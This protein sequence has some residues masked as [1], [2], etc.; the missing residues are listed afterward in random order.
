MRTCVGLL[1]GLV[2]LAG[3]GSPESGVEGDLP[4]EYAE[5]I[6]TATGCAE[7]QEVFDTAETTSAA[8]RDGGDSEGA[9]QYTAVM[10]AADERMRDV[11]C[12][13]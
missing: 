1:L 3:C 7:L 13:D 9:G 2:L 11:G 5:I 10:R 12:Y 8:R 6:D 4:G